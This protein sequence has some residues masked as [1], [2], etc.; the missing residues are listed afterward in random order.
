[1]VE[2]P[3]GRSK[4]EFEVDPDRIL[5][6]ITPSDVVPSRDPELEVVRA[7]KDPIG[8]PTIGELSPKGKT[9]AIAV[10][11]VTRVT[12]T[13]ILLPP[14]LRLL[15]EEGARRDDIRI[16]I[17]LGTHRRM[18]EQEM[19]EKYGAEVVEEYEVVNHAFDDESQLKYMG[20]VAGDVPVWINKDYV[21]A[22]IRIATGNLIPHFNA[23]WG[24]GA[25][26]LLPGLAGEET[27]GRMHVH[28]AVTTPNGLG[29]EE[30]PTRKLI[31]AFAE[32]VGIHLLV[33][34]AITR[35]REIVK[36]YAGHFVEAHRRGIAFAKGIYGVEAP[37]EADITVSSS[38]PADIEFWQGEKGLFSADLATKRN[39]TIILLTPCPEG[40]S[41]MHPMWIEYLQRS[42]EDLRE[43]YRMGD[44]DDLVALGVALN[45]VYARERHPIYIVSDGIT[46]KE[47]EK[48][49][50]K[51][52]KDV[53]EA[54][55]I[56]SRNHG[57]K[58]KVNILTH[59]GET[60][61]VIIGER[62]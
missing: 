9:I 33:N 60:Y 7:L 32:K 34:T 3:Y 59:G 39:G 29:M 46:D 61:P 13:H 54:L 8:G 28:S 45:V 21:S 26:I 37:G 53:D 6:V 22:D 57:L 17:A 38:Y 15:E 24:A 41:V 2:V 40:V 43:M 50:F 16:V 10:D 44:V 12:P 18:T 31:D 48:M 27:V 51:K 62:L 4:V 49:G 42:P 52:F 1:M 19:K 11:D 23:G 20:D 5:G 35:N 14:L 47:A 30:N 36:V 25:K 58:S 56:A 55:E